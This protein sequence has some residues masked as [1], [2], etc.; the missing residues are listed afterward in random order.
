MYGFSLGTSHRQRD[1]LFC[2][3]KHKGLF[4]ILFFTGCLRS[5]FHHTV[6]CTRICLDDTGAETDI[7]IY[8]VWWKDNR[9]EE[10]E[11]ILTDSRQ[12]FYLHIH[13]GFW[14]NLLVLLWVN[15]PSR[16]I[17]PPVFGFLCSLTVHSHS[18]HHPS[19]VGQEFIRSLT[20][21][22]H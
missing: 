15:R 6:A 16:S 17:G 13:S 19:S 11:D 2:S 20:N 8:W 12:Y 14:C 7:D 3:V 22:M 4:L 18:F 9:D 1:L 10:A 21:S 5:H